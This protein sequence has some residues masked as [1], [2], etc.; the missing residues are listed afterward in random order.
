MVKVPDGIELDDA[1][2]V[3]MKG[4]TVEY[5]LERCYKVQPGQKV[6]FW[7]A[8]GGVGQIAGQWG[9]HLGAEMIGVTAGADNC[10]RTRSWAMPTPST[11]HPRTSP[12]GCSE[13]T[14]GKG[15]PV[16]Y[17]SVGKASFD[18]SIASLGVY[19][20][21]VSFGATTGVAPAVSPDLLQKSAR[22]TS[23]GRR[24]PTTWRRA[25]TTCIRRP[26]SSRW[27]RAGTS[28]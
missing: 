24:W 8:S 23:P 10:A 13:L 26:A 1:A 7:A 28:S 15:V 27:C 14:G 25:P 5:L 11:A 19:G 20:I 21:F 4:M 6:L 9:Q 22:S 16:V 17:D 2:A 12:P 18:A 3:M